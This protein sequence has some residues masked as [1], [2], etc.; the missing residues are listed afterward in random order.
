MRI[1][2]HSL[3]QIAIFRFVRPVDTHHLCFRTISPNPEAKMKALLRRLIAG[4]GV[5]RRGVVGVRRFDSA[6]SFNRMNDAQLRDIGLW[7]ADEQTYLP[8][9]RARGPRDP[10]SRHRW[11]PG[12][13]GWQHPFRSDETAPGRQKPNIG[14][15]NA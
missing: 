4:L 8:A 13:R 6:G 1:H 12:R 11:N 10:V 3:W 2:K 15:L 7:R 14:R 9:A 5:S